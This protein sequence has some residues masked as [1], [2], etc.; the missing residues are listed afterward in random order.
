MLPSGPTIA[1]RHAS[2]VFVL[3]LTVVD[4][5]GSDSWVAKMSGF[6]ATVRLMAGLDGVLSLL[7]A[8]LA[9]RP[10]GDLEVVCVVRCTRLGD[11]METDGF[12]SLGLDRRSF[13]T[14]ITT[15]GS[16]PVKV[17]VYALKISTVG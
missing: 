12:G 11:D 3:V 1:R 4:V 9:L 10:D 15:D 16:V 13:E 17:A 8:S 5:T 6:Y 2:C 14:R 7:T